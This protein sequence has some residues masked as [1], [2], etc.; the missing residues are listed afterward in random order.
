M[1][2]Q[3]EKW[4]SS[5]TILDDVYKDIAKSI[6]SLDEVDRLASKKSA[7]APRPPS[8]YHKSAVSESELKDT[9]ATLGYATRKTSKENLWNRSIS[10]SHLASIQES[11]TSSPT[12]EDPPL[13]AK[14]SS[15][16]KSRFNSQFS[17][18]RPT[19]SDDSSEG[20]KGR[21][22]PVKIEG[23]KKIDGLLELVDALRVY[24]GKLRSSEYTELAAFEAIMLNWEAVLKVCPG[25]ASM[26][27]LL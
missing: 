16:K 27:A 26:G 5:T 15:L 18:S 4:R 7:V 19:D 23:L 14:P 13:R 10:M 21:P 22:V 1:E 3:K 17:S 20:G 6:P 2:G 8:A 25:L 24:L 9:P 11:E 12:K